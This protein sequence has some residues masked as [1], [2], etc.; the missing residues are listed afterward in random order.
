MAAL[1]P[2]TIGRLLLHLVRHPDSQGAPKLQLIL[3]APASSLSASRRLF[4]AQQGNVKEC[5]HAGDDGKLGD[6]GI[7]EID[8][9]GERPQPNRGEGRQA[10]GGGNAGL[11]TTTS[12]V[13]DINGPFTDN[14]GNSSS[15][16]VATGIPSAVGGGAGSISGSGGAGLGYAADGFTIVDTGTDG[17]QGASGSFA[18]VRSPFWLDGVHVVFLNSDAI[19]LCRLFAGRERV[20]A[21]SEDPKK[22][23][24]T[25]GP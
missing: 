5:L 16:L 12:S 25:E 14:V 9:K 17:S 24:K 2:S 15:A 13:S 23:S 20:P 18:I 4:F 7:S 3:V 19:T 1:N 11:V 21:L 6:A 10:G 8:G 22:K